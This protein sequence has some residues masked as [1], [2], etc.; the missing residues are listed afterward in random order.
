[1]RV[2]LN[3]YPDSKIS[4]ADIIQRLNELRRLIHH[5]AG[6]PVKTRVIVDATEDTLVSVFKVLALR[7]KQNVGDMWP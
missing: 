6:K 7:E 4:D 3:D 5:K 1:V 2:G